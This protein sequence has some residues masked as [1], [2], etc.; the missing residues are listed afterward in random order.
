MY[1]WMALSVNSVRYQQ[2]NYNIDASPVI[3][4]RSEYFCTAIKQ[5]ILKQ[6]RMMPRIIYV[7][8]ILIRTFSAVVT[9]M[10]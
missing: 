3:R 6:T 9:E 7:I 1:G 5:F 4:Q 8:N 2:L 10:F